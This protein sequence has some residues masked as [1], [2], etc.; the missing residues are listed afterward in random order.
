MQRL[1]IEVTG[2]RAYLQ[3]DPFDPI[4]TTSMGPGYHGEPRLHRA[5]GLLRAEE[6]CLK[7]ETRALHADMVG[8]PGNLVPPR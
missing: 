8:N 4:E 7:L 6:S 5:P 1:A 3:V 2:V